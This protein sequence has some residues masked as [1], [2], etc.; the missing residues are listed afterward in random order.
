MN[1][2][3]YEERLGEARGVL[4]A[5]LEAAYHD[6]F[7]LS[8]QVL[9]RSPFS[10]DYL[11]LFLSGEEKSASPLL[12]ARS[13]LLYYAKSSIHYA[14]YLVKK[15]LHAISGQRA[16]TFESGKDAV[17]VDVVFLVD[18]IRA[19][20]RFDERYF[21]PGLSAFLKDNNIR[22][23][24]LPFFYSGSYQR[25]PF[26]LFKVFRILKAQD[27]PVLTEFQLLNIIDILRIS[28]F[29]LAYPFHV[30]RFRKTLGAATFG[31]RI[32]RY[33]LVRALDHVTFYSYIRYLVGRRIAAL[34][35]SSLK[36]ISWY[37]NQPMNKN[38]YKG[39]RSGAGSVAVYGAQLF[40]HSLDYHYMMPDA[41][42][43]SYGLSP[44]VVVVG[45]SRYIHDDGA[46]PYRVGPSLRNARLFA[47]TSP[48]TKTPDKDIVVF[49]HLFR[50]DTTHLLRLLRDPA[51]EEFKFLLKP[52]PGL[53]I[54]GLGSLVPG[55]CRITDEDLYTLLGHACVAIGGGSG[56]L[57]E[58][59]ALG[60]PVICVKSKRRFDYNR[61]F[62]DAGEGVIWSEVA[63]AGELQKELGRIGMMSGSAAIAELAAGYRNRCFVEP[64]DEAIRKAFDF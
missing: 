11:E 39:L 15:A 52:H 58:S 2:S 35:F 23:A 8:N 38:L 43:R 5:A 1:P 25:K 18:S 47:Q 45:G 19:A 44:D 20:G 27:E 49:L 29:I 26:E 56:S 54:D 42:E 60:V 63:T 30:L 12:I 61:G 40:P 32:L 16:K 53:P 48:K 3:S 57:V 28:L 10:N 6:E 33:E 9:G 21:F 62:F 34:P 46:V 55:N 14:L 7:L 41:N 64:T 36:V 59:V 37:E 24:Y 22:Y 4:S 50:E 13:L 31:N 51:L 17:L